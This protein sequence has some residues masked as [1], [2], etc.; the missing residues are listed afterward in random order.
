[1]NQ[2]LQFIGGTS[3]QKHQW[4][5]VYRIAFQAI[6]NVTDYK[7]HKKWWWALYETE[8]LAANRKTIL[9]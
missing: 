3:E 9:P 4:G 6:K 7:K 5:N 2:Q 8:L 1:M